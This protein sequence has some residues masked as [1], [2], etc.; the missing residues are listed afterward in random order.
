LQYWFNSPLFCP[1]AKAP[2]APGSLGG[3]QD[4][5]AGSSVARVVVGALG[6]QLIGTQTGWSAAAR[7]C[8]ARAGG[9]KFMS[10]TT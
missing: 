9:S 6:L 5:K 2:W 10:M 8:S 1:C 4:E 3:D 7:G